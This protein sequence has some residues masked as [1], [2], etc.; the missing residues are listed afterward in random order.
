M[1]MRTAR[2]ATTD[3][4]ADEEKDDYEQ[5]ETQQAGDDLAEGRVQKSQYVI[6]GCGFGCCG[7]GDGDCGGGSG[8][9]GRAG[10]GSKG[11]KV[12]AF[13]DHC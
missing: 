4:T 3:H 13:Q 9:G 7:G 2:A 8:A 1:V 6:G 11:W 12:A 10:G 5:N